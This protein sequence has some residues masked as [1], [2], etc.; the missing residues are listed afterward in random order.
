VFGTLEEGDNTHTYTPE[1]GTNSL[2]TKPAAQG[3]PI[4]TLEVLLVGKVR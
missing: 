4:F 2:I 1:R 3:K